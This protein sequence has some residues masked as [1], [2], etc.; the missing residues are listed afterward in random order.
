MRLKCTA[1]PSRGVSTRSQRAEEP[2]SQM[3][4]VAAVNFWAGADAA[5]TNQATDRV[6]SGKPHLPRM[7]LVLA[8][9]AFP[10]AVFPP[11][12]QNPLIPKALLACITPL[13][14]CARRPILLCS[15]GCSLAHNLS[16]LALGE[17]RL[18]Q[19]ANRL[20]FLALEDCNLGKFAFRDDADLLDLLHGF[21]A[22]H[23]LRLHGLHGLHGWLA[24]SLLHRK[25]HDNQTRKSVADAS[26]GI[27]C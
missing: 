17:G 18:R 1:R 25:G 15:C 11:T 9:K 21:H 22:L 19:A 2:Q 3:S 8:Y 12:A 14:Q 23:C 5:E 13:L 24:G 10:C 6:D 26:T 27:G 20:H 4:T 7:A 16:A